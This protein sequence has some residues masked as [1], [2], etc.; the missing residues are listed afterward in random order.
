MLLQLKHTQKKLDSRI[1]LDHLSLSIAGGKIIGLLGPN[2]SGKTTLLKLL[3]GLTRPSE[4]QLFLNNQPYT[5]PQTSWGI[6]Y[7]PDCSIFPHH[8][9]V[10]QTITFYESNFPDFDTKKAHTILADLEIPTN[11]RLKNMSL[12]QQER[13]ML[14]LVLSRHT[15]LLLLDEPLAAI[16]V[17][18][19]DEILYLLSTYITPHITVIISTHLVYD[20]QDL[21]DEVIFLQRG[22]ITLY[23][24]VSL[25][26]QQTHLS[27]LDFYR[28]HYS[29]KKASIE[30]NNATPE[31]PSC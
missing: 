5:Y 6:N 17:I 25:I 27:L 28:S 1:I 19:R 29:K 7:L 12:G 15:Q 22:Q 20:M 4:G 9:S 21:F 3:A 8:Y 2:G 10:A 18:T 31:V 23:Q 13:L 24:P 30:Q 14:A 11:T 26:Q 16:D